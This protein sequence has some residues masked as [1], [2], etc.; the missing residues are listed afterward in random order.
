MPQEGRMTVQPNA[1]EAPAP[2]APEPTEPTA[3]APEA[4]KPAEPAPAKNVWEDPVTAKAE[5]ERLRKENAK[6][7]TTAKQTAADEAKAAL[8]QEIGKALGLVK[9]EPVD[10]AKLT[11]Q[12][13]SAQADAKRAQVALAVYQNAATA[14]ADPLAL[15]DSAT[16]L[17]KAAALDPTDVDG[18]KAAMTEAVTANPRLGAAPESRTPAPNP[19][20][21]SSG[22]GTQN[23]AQLSEADVKRMYAEK[24]YDGI[25]KAQAEGRLSNLLGT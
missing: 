16:F 10:P 1:P 25:S 21:G 3:V 24:D 20:Q 12:I 22:G 7:R 17:A 6:D 18:L 19:A 14:G 9:D 15:L 11:E 5:I 4:A 8:A 2:E 13:A 23:V